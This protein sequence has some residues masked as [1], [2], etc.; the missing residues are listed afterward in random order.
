MFSVFKELPWLVGEAQICVMTSHKPSSSI[1][2]WLQCHY[3]SCNKPKWAIKA[4]NGNILT[5]QS[6]E[7]WFQVSRDTTLHINTYNGND[8]FMYCLPMA[9]TV[10]VLSVDGSGSSC[11]PSPW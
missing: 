1:K 9:V 7:L 3:R 10:C 8:R 5:T 11:T 6:S 4:Y 2:N